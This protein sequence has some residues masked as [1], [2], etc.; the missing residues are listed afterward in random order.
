MV[1]VKQMI[2]AVM[3]DNSIMQIYRVF[4][5]FTP[6][7]QR[8]WI[9]FDNLVEEF[10][11]IVIIA[12]MGRFYSSEDSAVLHATIMISISSRSRVLLPQF[13]AVP[14][15]M[16]S[17]DMPARRKNRMSSVGTKARSLTATGGSPSWGGHLMTQPNSIEWRPVP[18]PTSRIELLGC[19]DKF[20]AIDASRQAGSASRT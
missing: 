9:E 18:H 3:S 7:L 5:T 17:T 4:S 14:P 1:P 8:I 2:L 20:E 13:P 19:S 15:H 12:I 6:R 11:G 16:L 10:Y